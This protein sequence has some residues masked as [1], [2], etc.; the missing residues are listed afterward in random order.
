MQTTIRKAVE[1]FYSSIVLGIFVLAV[2]TLLMGQIGIKI[3]TPPRVVELFEAPPTGLQRIPVDSTLFNVKSKKYKRSVKM[4]S[5]ARFISIRETLDNTDFFLPA[6][7]DLETYIRLRLD[8]ETRQLWQQIVLQNF[9]KQE[10][11]S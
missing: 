6:V 1:K 9:K 4:D 2:P 7:V 10:E 11:R 5:T 8:Y 3:P